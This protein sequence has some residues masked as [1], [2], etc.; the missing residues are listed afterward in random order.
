[1]LCQLHLAQKNTQF[2]FPSHLISRIKWRWK[3][4][5]QSYL[6]LVHLFVSQRRTSSS[7]LLNLL[8]CNSKRK[9]YWLCLLF[10]Y[11]LACPEPLDCWQRRKGKQWEKTQ[12]ANVLATASH[13]GPTCL[14]SW[15]LSVSGGTYHPAD[16]GNKESSLLQC[17][18]K[19]N[20]N[21][22]GQKG[23]DSAELAVTDLSHHRKIEQYNPNL[24]A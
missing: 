9:H 23:N 15:D 17:Q 5:G 3:I 19:T 1:M 7:V 20:A 22:N 2:T 24:N 13:T 18:I 4:G 21:P 6:S 16:K 10:S 14:S 11:S 12:P 8:H